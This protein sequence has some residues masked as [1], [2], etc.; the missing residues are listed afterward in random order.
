MF[1]GGSPPEFI[2]KVYLLAIAPGDGL[3]ALRDVEVRPVSLSY[4]MS[5]SPEETG[6]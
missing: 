5:V 4:R 6:Q 1:G 3:C 2:L